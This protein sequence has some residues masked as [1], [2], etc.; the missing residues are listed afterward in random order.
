MIFRCWTSCRPCDLQ[1]V[2]VNTR[3]DALIDIPYSQ[4]LVPLTRPG[5]GVL[6][7][8]AQRTRT[9]PDFC[10]RYGITMASW[11]HTQRYFSCRQQRSYRN[12]SRIY[13]WMCLHCWPRCP[14]SQM[15]AVPALLLPSK[16]VPRSCCTRRRWR[17]RSRGIFC[18]NP[19]TPLADHFQPLHRLP[20]HV[21]LARRRCL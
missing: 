17:R 4:A 14:A 16:L 21:S 13:P 5:Q 18:L 9:T 8:L 10:A 20:P 1:G 2:C 7:F 6:G 12:P 15:S 11:Q 3:E 19:L